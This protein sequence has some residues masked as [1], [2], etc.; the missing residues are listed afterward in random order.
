MPIA[1][2]GTKVPQNK[3][4]SYHYSRDD[5]NNWFYAFVRGETSQNKTEFIRLKSQ[6]ASFI[7][8]EARTSKLIERA[9]RRSKL[10]FH[11]SSFIKGKIGKNMQPIGNIGNIYYFIWQHMMS[12]RARVIFQLACI[13]LT[14][15]TILN[16]GCVLYRAQHRTREVKAGDLRLAS[17]CTRNPPSSSSLNARRKSVVIL[18]YSNMLQGHILLKNETLYNMVRCNHQHYAKSH[19]YDYGSPAPKTGKWLASLFVLNGIRYKTFSILSYMDEYDVIVWIDHDAVFFNMELSVEY[20]LDLMRPGA[21]ILMAE[22]LPGY[23]FNTGLQ[24]IKV[25][26]WTKAFY[27]KAINGLLKT[28]TNAMYADQPILYKLHDSV[29][30][31]KEK[32]QIH[33]PRNDFQAFLKVKSDFRNRSWVVHAT[34]CNCDLT[35]YTAPPACHATA[36]NN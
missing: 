14:S 25:S 34:Q 26:N 8:A 13:F 22:D 5:N 3:V 24:V 35:H 18:S 19:G 2:A 31:A 28:D 29:M 7:L 6:A 33:S 9:T 20:W 36:G 32:L 23:K 27:S 4:P 11:P 15:Y 12:K 17:N 1:R 10:S 30:D 21:E 16:G